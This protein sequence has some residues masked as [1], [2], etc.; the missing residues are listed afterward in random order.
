MLLIE[1]MHDKMK[2]LCY[3]DA[4]KNF[5]VNLGYDT[6]Y[7]RD[8]VPLAD[9]VRRVKCFKAEKA[10]PSKYHKKE[11]VGYVKINKIENYLTQKP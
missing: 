8:M 1:R 10:M 7:L 2:R 11:K 5:R 9:K 6:N 4:S 3:A